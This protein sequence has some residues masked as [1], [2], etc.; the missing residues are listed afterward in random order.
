MPGSMWAEFIN[1]RQLR[2]TQPKPNVR[3]SWHTAPAEGSAKVV[4][5]KSIPR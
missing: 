5:A 1:A 3:N 2:T 4:S